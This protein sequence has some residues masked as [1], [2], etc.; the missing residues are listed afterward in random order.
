MLSTFSRRFTCGVRDD[1]AVYCGL[2]IPLLDLACAL[3]RRNGWVS[4]CGNTP[5]DLNSQALGIIGEL[6]G[7]I[8]SCVWKLKWLKYGV[9]IWTP[10]SLLGGLFT[11][12]ER[13][14][15]GVITYR[16]GH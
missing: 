6:V 1:S 2:G 11:K 10:L 7:Q 15:E 9:R 3:C 4:S 12:M 5:R 14:L 16:E 13:P 8:F